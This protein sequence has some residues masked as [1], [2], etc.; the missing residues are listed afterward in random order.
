[1][2]TSVS[3]R[4]STRC[5]RVLACMLAWA[6]APSAQA[7]GQEDAE[8][9]PEPSES[10]GSTSATAPAD[11]DAEET[12]PWQTRFGMSLEAG[13]PGGVG[14][15]VL[16]QPW[17]WLRVHVGSARNTL[18]LGVRAGAS[19]IPLDLFVSPSLDLEYGHYFNADYSKLLTQLHGQPTTPATRIRDVGYDQLTASLGLGF[20]PSR[21]VTLFG[22]VGISY[23]SIRVKD[24]ESF[25]S[26][27]VDDPDLTARPLTL[28]L[29]SPAIKL[30]LIVYFH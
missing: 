25:I 13:A 19:L 2:T 9:L 12:P 7:R 5:A 4:G 27:A 16:V 29:T 22:N 1:M 23:W 17:R 18:G 11:P 26:E 14:A 24:A 20:S 10:T 6:V 21:R 30:G 8:V 3:P 28:S 15:S